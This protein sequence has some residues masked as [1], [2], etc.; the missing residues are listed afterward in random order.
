MKQRLFLFFAMGCLGMTTE[1]FFTAI[2]DIAL[3]K[4]EV[5]AKLMGYSYIWMFPIYGSSGILFPMMWRVIE[6]WNVL[7]RMCVYGAG[8][9]VVEF[10]TGWLLDVFTGQCPWEYKE[11]IHIMGYIRLDFFPFWAVFGLVIEKLLRF[12]MRS[13]HFSR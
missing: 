3:G 5:P 9:I 10:V 12:L 11:G 4:A 7:L 1:I 13:V 2:Y 6:K 8:I